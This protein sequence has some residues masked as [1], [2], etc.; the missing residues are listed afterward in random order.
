[1][2]P[3]A[4][5]LKGDKVLFAEF[6]AQVLGLKLQ[7]FH[8]EWLD[9]CEHT[10]RLL[11]LAPANHGK[12]TIVSI[13][14]ALH[15]V[16]RNPDIRIGIFTAV[17]GLAEAIVRQ[18][19]GCIESDTFASIF[20]RFKP[21]R[22]RIWNQQE[23]LIQR[24]H[25]SAASKD[26]TGFAT[27]IMGSAVGRRFDLVVA[28]DV[29]DP[30][31]VETSNSREAVRR[32]WNSIVE[33]CVPQGGKIWVVGTRYHAA[34]LYAELEASEIYTTKVY[35]ALAE[36]GRA[37]WPEQETAAYHATRKQL[38]PHAFA[39]RKQ[40]E[41]LPESAQAFPPDRVDACLDSTRVLH[42]ARE[43]LPERDR[44]LRIWQGVD[45]AISVSRRAAF[46]VILTVGFRLNPPEYVILGYVRDKISFPRQV[47]Q[48]IG[49]WNAWQPIEILVE[50][51]QYQAALAEAAR[52]SAPGLPVKEVYTTWTKSH[53]EE[54]IPRLS[55]LIEAGAIK[56]PC[57]DAYSLE[58]AR[59]LSQELKSYPVG[60]HSDLMMALWFITKRTR[61]DTI[62]PASAY[63]PTVARTMTPIGLR[64]W[65][66]VNVPVRR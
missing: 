13:I 26:A 54:G 27:G 12:T 9:L 36:D 28:D 14:A 58:F 4:T 48:V 32:R 8:R 51:N 37:L 42:A 10:D 49:Q 46:F 21:P 43:G 63:R 16:Y 1:M 22:A 3:L 29:V 15:E 65:R 30:E 17:D 59:L 57:G 34:D 20:G 7:A 47:Q 19:K 56:I 33:Y 11:L 25:G 31:N 5:L 39:R 64:R 45:L 50:S 38:D 24:P 23:Y 40:N 6:C 41:L 60:K 66:I 2:V 55:S 53:L 44:D 61:Y 18:H 52:A 62:T 35:K